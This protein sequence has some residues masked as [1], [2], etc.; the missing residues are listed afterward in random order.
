MR[1]LEV[2]ARLARRLLRSERAELGGDAVRVEL[3]GRDRGGGDAFP[4][5]LGI[6]FQER[7]ARGGALHPLATVQLEQDPATR[8]LV[9]ARVGRDVQATGGPVRLLGRV[10]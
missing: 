10:V 8:S 9:R 4:R 3:G 6:A 1:I 2:T 5:V 7:C